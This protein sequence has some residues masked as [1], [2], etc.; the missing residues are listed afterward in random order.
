VKGLTME[1]RF[2]YNDIGYIFKNLDVLKNFK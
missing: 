2:C 1:N